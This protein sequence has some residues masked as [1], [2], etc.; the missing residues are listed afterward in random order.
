MLD[1]DIIRWL[2]PRETT[3]DTGEWAKFDYLSL[4]SYAGTLAE[5]ETLQTTVYGKAL[6]EDSF[7]A[8]VGK[9]PNRDAPMEDVWTRVIDAPS[10]KRMTDAAKKGRIR[11]AAL[12]EALATLVAEKT[13]GQDPAETDFEQIAADILE[14]MKEEPDTEGGSESD[15][16]Q[17]EGEG[18]SGEGEPTEGEE[19]EGESQ[20]GEGEPGEGE[21]GEGE[22]DG[23]EEG[24]GDSGEGEPDRGESGKGEDGEDAPAKKGGTEQTA[25]VEMDDEGSLTETTQETEEGEEPDGM[26][27]GAI[28]QIRQAIEGADITEEEVL[29]VVTEA[30]ARADFMESVASLQGGADEPTSYDALRKMADHYDVEEFSRLLGWAEHHIHGASR[31]NKIGEETLIGFETGGWDSNVTVEEMVAVA[32]G[33]LAALGRFAEGSLHKVKVEGDRPSGRGAVIFMFDQSSSMACLPGKV[34]MDLKSTETH[35]HKARLL[36][37]ALATVLNKEGRDL[38]CVAWSNKVG[39]MDLTRIAKF[40]PRVETYTH[41]EPGFGLHCRSFL[42]GGTEILAPLEEATYVAGEYENPCDILVV[43]D[44]EFAA[45]GQT[46]GMT[47]EEW[48]EKFTL[49]ANHILGDFREWGGRCWA[50]HIG[51]SE[52]SKNLAFCDGVVSEAQINASDASGHL[53]RQIVEDRDNAAIKQL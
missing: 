22:S 24:E 32:G 20:S 21:P 50:I 19:G 9:R 52:E 6:V 30:E 15:D 34:W 37:F 14:E 27:M 48:R 26:D 3:F 35:Y 31:N 11:Q 51:D 40:R 5:L 38:V 39:K 1:I 12:T 42:N 13:F 43:T 53:L 29:S 44:A 47:N 8:L 36:E 45:V 2:F 23:D 33:D 41:G 18:D 16:E 25:S 10:F 28:R 17:G 46:G 49:A 4:I 7:Y